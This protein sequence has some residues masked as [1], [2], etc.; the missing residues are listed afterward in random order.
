MHIVM[1]TLYNVHGVKLDEIKSD[2]VRS[3][4]CGQVH[5]ESTG[6]FIKFWKMRKK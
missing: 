5:K 2:R 4:K 6:K 3:V 1:Y